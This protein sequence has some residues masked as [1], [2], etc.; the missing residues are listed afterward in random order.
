MFE[1]ATARTYLGL[2][3]LPGIVGFQKPEG[4]VLNP[5]YYVFP[6]LTELAAAFPSDKWPPL[7]VGGLALVQTACFGKWKL[8]PDWTLVAPSWVTLAPGQDAVFGY[9]AIR[10]PLYAAWDDP[11]S[12]LLAPFADFWQSAPAKKWDPATVDLRYDTFGPYEALP[13]M[14]AVRDFTLACARKTSI[15][16]AAI[17]ALQAEESYYSASLK[18]LAKMAIHERFAPKRN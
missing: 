6:A 1:K 12:P 15:T 4:V 10:V 14:M 17:P 8:S 11:A 18:L 13:G 2:Q 5:S 9:N 7:H 3:L 16:V